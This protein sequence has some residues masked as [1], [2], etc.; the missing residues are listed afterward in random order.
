LL[1][2][3]LLDDP[4][5]K[6]TDYKKNIFKKLEKFPDQK[7]IELL[8]KL[9]DDLEKSSSKTKLKVKLLLI[10]YFEYKN[11]VVKIVDENESDNIIKTINEIKIKLSYPDNDKIDIKS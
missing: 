4:V 10:D 1:K 2:S 9:E 7:L 6:L 8:V 11:S 5:I 3:D